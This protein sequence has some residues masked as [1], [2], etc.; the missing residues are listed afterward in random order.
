MK[1][2]VNEKERLNNVIKELV[3]TKGIQLNHTNLDKIEIQSLLLDLEGKVSPELIS[4]IMEVTTKEYR[5][6]S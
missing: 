4:G 1:Q 6:S 3:Q 5:Q 2:A